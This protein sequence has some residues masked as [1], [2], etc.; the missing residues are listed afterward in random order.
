[1]NRNR[2]GYGQSLADDEG[3]SRK[4]RADSREITGS[5]RVHALDDDLTSRRVRLGRRRRKFANRRVYS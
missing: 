2:Y 3:S 5:T 4:Q 1:M